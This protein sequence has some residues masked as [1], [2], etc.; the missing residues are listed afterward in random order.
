MHIRLLALVGG[1][2]FSDT[3]HKNDREMGKGDKPLNYTF[4]EGS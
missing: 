2:Y 4:S 3:P 1:V